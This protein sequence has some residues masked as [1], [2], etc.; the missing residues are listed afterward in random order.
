MSKESINRCLFFKLVMQFA[1]SQQIL[2]TWTHCAR[3]CWK[4]DY[5][6]DFT[7]RRICTLQGWRQTRKTV[8][9]NDIRMLNHHDD[10]DSILSASE[11]HIIG[12]Q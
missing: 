4:G 6:V 11:G 1:L 3:F 2:G 7:L 10:K 5:D 9:D 12:L 8:G